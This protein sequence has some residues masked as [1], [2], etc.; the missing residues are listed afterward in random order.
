MN[1]IQLCNRDTS[2]NDDTQIKDIDTI[3]RS[4]SSIHTYLLLL[5]RS[6]N[7]NNRLC[8]DDTLPIVQEY[9]PRW[10]EILYKPHYLK[11]IFYLVCNG[12]CYTNG[13][14]KIFGGDVGNTTKE[15]NILRKYGII[16][17]ASINDKDVRVFNAHRQVFNIDF[18]HFKKAVFYRLSKYGKAFYCDIPFNR[19]LPPHIFSLV[20]NWKE[21]LKMSHKEHENQLE[22][23][24]QSYVRRITEKNFVFSHAQNLNWIKSKADRIGK[25]PEDYLS[26]L[27]KR[28]KKDA[29]GSLNEKKI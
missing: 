10:I 12:I 3:L 21:K 6:N 27:E 5:N 23:D 24:Y 20:D 15:L 7:N 22:M 8:N 18:W 11:I 26:E 25:D 19:L 28:Y 9:I 13:L 2:C 29:E 16:K 1:K 14:V 17:V 4:S